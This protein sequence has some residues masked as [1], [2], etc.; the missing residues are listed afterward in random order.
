MADEI[1]S[2]KTQNYYSNSGSTQIIRAIIRI[3]RLVKNTWSKALA[4]AKDA[5]SLGMGKA[6]SMAMVM[7]MAIARATGKVASRDVAKACGMATAMAVTIPVAKVV[8]K[9]RG[10]PPYNNLCPHSSSVP[11]GN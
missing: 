2:S 7:A 11:Y 4:R 1:I 9:A 8:S 6:S 3:Q 10:A 5:A